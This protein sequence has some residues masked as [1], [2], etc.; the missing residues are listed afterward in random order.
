MLPVVEHPFGEH[1]GSI[2]ILRIFSESVQRDESV[3]VSG[4]A[5]E[6]S[7][8]FAQDTSMPNDFA[9][10]NGALQILLIVEDFV[11]ENESV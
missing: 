1:R 10:F 6:K 2:F 7:V 9:T 4:D 5:V 8:S 3:S 11:G